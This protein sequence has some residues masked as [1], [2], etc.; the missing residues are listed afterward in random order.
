M[1]KI[2]QSHGNN[3]FHCV[4]FFSGQAKKKIAGNKIKDQVKDLFIKDKTVNLVM[5]YH[6]NRIYFGA[7]KLHELDHYCYYFIIIIIIII[8]ITII[9]RLLIII[10]VDKLRYIIHII[11]KM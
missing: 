6:S 4:R 9:I 8:I 3:H 11:Q 7:K 2:V 1:R 10:S 5:T